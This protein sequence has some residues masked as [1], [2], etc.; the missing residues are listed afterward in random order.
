MAQGFW[1]ESGFFIEGAF[2]QDTGDSPFN[3]GLSTVTRH[4]WAV[5]P[6]FARSWGNDD[7]LVIGGVRF[8][9][10]PNRA[11]KFFTGGSGFDRQPDSGISA[12]TSAGLAD[13]GIDLLWNQPD[14]SQGTV[15]IT[16][17][18]L[19]WVAKLQGAGLSFPTWASQGHLIVGDEVYLVRQRLSDTELLLDPNP[20]NHPV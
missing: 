11:L 10:A 13:V 14:Y 18:D 12:W 3:D 6:L 20:G 15:T 5:D 4:F 1:G 17:Q 16:T 2:D 8:D 7:G 19:S 9:A